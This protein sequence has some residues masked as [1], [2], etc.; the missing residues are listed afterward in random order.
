[1]I[2]VVG[3]VVVGI[4]DLLFQFIL[5][6]DK[7]WKS[8]WAILMVWELLY[9]LVLWWTMIVFPPSLKSRDFAAM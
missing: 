8:E 7:Y 9:L 1:M 4:C 3:A 5:D 2:G 6:P